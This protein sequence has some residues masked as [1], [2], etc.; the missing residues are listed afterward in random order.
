MGGINKRNTTFLVEY[1]VV[2]NCYL[3]GYVVNDII[4]DGDFDG[5]GFESNALDD[6]F[7]YQY[8]Y[9]DKIR[10]GINLDLEPKVINEIS[11]NMNTL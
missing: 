7:R 6:I 9:L 11:F 5:I 2:N 8:E 4:E 1:S 10:S 3:R